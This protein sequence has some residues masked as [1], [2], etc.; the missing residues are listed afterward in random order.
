MTSKSEVDDNM[1][2]STIENCNTCID[3]S[4]KIAQI[5]QLIHK[6]DYLACIK[7]KQLQQK[8]NEVYQEYKCIY[9]S[10]NEFSAR[11]N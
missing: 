4:E 11:P 9:L 10:K 2:S 1:V 3:K 8:I 7:C 6:E 5:H